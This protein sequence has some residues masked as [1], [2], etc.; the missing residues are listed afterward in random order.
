[1]STKHTSKLA[2]PDQITSLENEG[3]VA[4]VAICGWCA[5]PEGFC[6]DGGDADAADQGDTVDLG[7]IV[8]FHVKIFPGVYAH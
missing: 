2:I 8:C 6:R 3:I 5:G 7:D 1:M 4:V